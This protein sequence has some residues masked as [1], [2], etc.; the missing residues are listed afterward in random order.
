MNYLRSLGRCD[1]GLESHSGHGCLVCIY[2]DVYVTNKT[3]SRLDD[4]TYYQLGYT[5]TLNYAYKLT[6][7]SLENIISGGPPLRYVTANPCRA[8]CIPC[9]G[10][11]EYFHRNPAS[12]RRRRKG[13]SRIWG[14]KILSRVSRY[15]N[16]R[17]TSLA[18][19]S[20]N[21]K[22]QTHPHVSQSAPH[23]QNR[24]YLTVIKIWS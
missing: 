16:L 5:L 19:T 15:S 3:G 8:G 17:M 9:E 21:C 10:G 4:W 22:R 1:R 13:R 23:Q 12:R 24:N 7:V 6:N 20:G 18:R 14:I 2:C 11:D